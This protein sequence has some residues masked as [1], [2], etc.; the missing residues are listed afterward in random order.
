ML[1]DRWAHHYYDN[2]KADQDEFED[3]DF[4]AEAEAMMNGND[5]DWEELS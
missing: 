3:P 5:D 1:T 2:P 4:E